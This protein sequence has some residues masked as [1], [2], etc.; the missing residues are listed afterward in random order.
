M[1]FLS[2]LFGSRKAELK[3]D[4]LP[5]GSF[6]VDRAGKV[7]TSTLPAIFP[8]SLVKDIARAVLG[9]FDGAHE[10]SLPLT[11]MQ[12]HFG[13]FKITA[14]EQRGGAIIFLAPKN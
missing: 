3:I 2:S 1:G 11:E 4:R 13:G 8:E 12:V 6:T 14:R 9:A 5:S 7:L 10:A